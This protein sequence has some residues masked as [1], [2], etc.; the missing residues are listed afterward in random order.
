MSTKRQKAASAARFID[1]ALELPVGTVSGGANIS[2]N[3][4]REVTVD[5]CYGIIACSEDYIKLSLGG[6]SVGISGNILTIK[7]LTEREVIIVGRIKSVEF[8]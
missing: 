2:L 7:S 3:S 5:G 8:C 4:D 1:R 6:K